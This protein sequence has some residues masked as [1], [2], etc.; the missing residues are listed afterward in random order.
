MNLGYA[1]LLG[2][3]QGLTEF[4]PISSSGHLVLMESLLPAFSRRGILFEI[5]L[6][7]GTLIAVVLY[8]RRDITRILYSFWRKSSGQRGESAQFRRLGWLILL[9]MVPTAIV[10]L[11]LHS[12]VEK[13]FSSPLIAGLFLLITAVILF[14]TKFFKGKGRSIGTI[15]IKDSLIIGLMQGLAIFPGLSRSGATISAGIFAGVDKEASARFSF[16]L[17]IPAIAGALLFDLKEL[18]YLARAD[19]LLLGYYAVGAAVAGLVGYLSIGLLLRIVKRFRLYL[20]SYYC[21]AVGM[22]TII[23]HLLKS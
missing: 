1:I 3:T 21:L 19:I 23:L 13:S 11:I 20:F 10:A 22:T 4:L 2:I 16:L 18:T 6:H 12:Y 9:A 14:A 8:F 5:L 17:S 7:T 15:G